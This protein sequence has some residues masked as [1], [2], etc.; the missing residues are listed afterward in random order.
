MSKQVILKH[1]ALIDLAIQESGDASALF[2]LANLN[3]IGI[4]DEPLPGSELMMAAIADDR[5]LKF[6]RTRK[7]KPV[8]IVP[9]DEELVGEGIE[10]WGIEF[11]FIVS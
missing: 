1:Q 9:R 2:E 4:T 6:T 3:G 7:V 5:N 11:D 8:T 10:F